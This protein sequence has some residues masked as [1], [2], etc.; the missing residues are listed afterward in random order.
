MAG[1]CRLELLRVEIRAG[2]GSRFVAVLTC[3]CCA[4]LHP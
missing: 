4:I 1:P 2:L 3:L